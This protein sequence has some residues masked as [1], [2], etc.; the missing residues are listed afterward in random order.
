MRN[1]AF[2]PGGRTSWPLATDQCVWGAGTTW[3]TSGKVSDMLSSAD[4]LIMARAAAELQREPGERAITEAIVTTAVEAVRDADAASL[5]VQKADGRRQSETL[6]STSEVARVCDETQHALPEGPQFDLTPQQM[7][8]SSS[9]VENDPRWP[10]WGPRAASLGV[11]SVLSVSL[12]ERGRAVG[13]L[14]LYAAREGR[15]RDSDQ[16]E[17]GVVFASHAAN[18]LAS[19][20]HIAGLE[21]ALASRHV[22][23]VAQGLLMGRYGLDQDRAFDLLRRIS[24]HENVKLVEVARRVV[25]TRG[26]PT[27]EHA[28][29][30]HPT[31]GERSTRPHPSRVST[32]RS[33]GS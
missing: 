23:G 32:G 14:N 17:L 24:S 3:G 25:D 20:R 7:W 18:A 26:V 22:I 10:R 5:T 13:A 27:S 2:M 16:T 1:D 21:I 12:Y 33:C 19:A 11:A 4:V 8:V 29:P 28:S 9:D 30:I 31:P 6:A 15:F